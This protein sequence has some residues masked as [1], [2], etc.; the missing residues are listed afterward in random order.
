MHSK[1]STNSKFEGKPQRNNSKFQ[2]LVN[3]DWGRK[4]KIRSAKFKGTR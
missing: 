4:N 1:R 3:L 2:K